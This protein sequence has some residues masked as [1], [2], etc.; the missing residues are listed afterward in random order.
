MGR[1]IGTKRRQRRGTFAAGRARV[2]ATRRLVAER[3]EPRM[4]LAADLLHVG[5]V[6][7]ETDF[8]ESESGNGS[9]EVADRFLLSF[10]GGA[11]DTQLREIRI[12]LDKDQDGLSVGDLIFDTAAGGRGKGAWHPFRVARIDSVSGERANVEAE[13]ADGGTELLVRLDQ[14]RSG[15]LLEFTI[16][17]DEVLRNH[18][19]LDRFN[20][21]LDVIASGQEMQDS[22]F[23]A[24][25]VAPHYEP[26]T[27]ETLFV[28]DYGNP[29]A[30]F[31]LRLPPNQGPPPDSF[32]S[33]TA[34]AVTTGV[35]QPKPISI[36]GTVWVDNDLDLVRRASEPGV[37]GVQL[38]LLR[39]DAGT[40]AWLDTGFRQVTNSQGGYEFGTSL[41]L[42]PGNYRVVQSPVKG[43]F[44]VG[45]VTGSVADQPTGRVI[46][47]NVISDIRML[48][49][50]THGRDYDFAHARPAELSGAVYLDD[51]DN[52]R[53][54]VGEPGLGGSRIRLVPIET[55]VAIETIETISRADGSFVFEGLPPGR[56]ELIQVTQPTGLQDG[57]DRPGTVDGRSV[58][59][60]D[61][62]G[63]AIRGIELLGG[64][65]GIDYWFGELALGELSGGVYLPPPG[66]DCGVSPDRKLPLEGVVIELLGPGGVTVASTTTGVDGRYRFQAIPKGAYTIVQTSP[67]GLLGGRAFVGII[68]GITVGSAVG[69]GMISEILMPAGG[70]GTRYD[71]CEAAPASLSGYVYHDAND[72]GR[73]DTGESPIAG[74]EIELYGTS[75]QPV[76]RTRT[77]AQ[78]RYEFNGLVP[79]EYQVRQV[80]PA[81]YFDGTDSAGSVDGIAIGVAENP[82]DRITGILLRQ[83]QTGIDYNFGELLSAS[84]SG[85]V[86]ADD[87]RNGRL[88]P[89]EN[90]LAGV[91]IE[92]WDAEDNRI[93]ARLTDDSGVYR[94]EGLRPGTYSLR[95]T[96]PTDFFQ[97]EEL[98]GTF[99]GDTTLENRID[100][101]RLPSAAVATE[102]D[103]TELSPARISGYVFRDGSVIVTERMP[104]PDE[105]RRFR[106]G[107]RRSDSLPISGVLIQLRDESGR[108]VAT[109]RLLPGVGADGLQIVTDQQGYFEFVGLAPGGYSLYQVQPAGYVDGL[110]TPGPLG[111]IAINAADLATDPRVSELAARLRSDPATD[112][113]HDAIVG[114]WLAPGDN[115]TENWFAEIEVVLVEPKLAEP[116]PPPPAPPL[117]P[118]PAP[119]EPPAE[120]QPVPPLLAPAIENAD[121]GVPVWDTFAGGLHVSSFGIHDQHL[122]TLLADSEYVVTWHLSVLNG[123]F[124][125]GNDQRSGLFKYT[126]GREHSGPAEPPGRIGRWLFVDRAGRRVEFGQAFLLGAEDGI[127][128]VGDFNGDGVDQIAIYASGQWFVDLNGNGV[129]DHGDLWLKLGTELDRPVVGDWDGDG[130]ADI[131]IFGRQ[132]EGDPEA[133]RRDPGLPT[134]ANKRRRHQPHA[135]VSQT[136]R[137]ARSESSREVV[138]GRLTDLAVDAVDHVFRYG[139]PPDTPVAGDWNGDGLDSVGI[140][141]GGRWTLDS[142]GDGRLTKDDD[143]AD[144]GQP[145]DIPIVG[146]WNGDGTANLGVV[147]GDWWIIDSD[148]DR[149]LTDNDYRVRIEKPSDNARPVTGDWDGDGQDEFGW[150]D[151]AG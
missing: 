92:L 35:Q 102:Y 119:P 24:D 33:R 145:G 22:W 77:D 68:D 13:V 14:F 7:I 78:G 89:G 95:Q 126:S 108:P 57:V 72:N 50:D 62:P 46:D 82:G 80:Q 61:E 76:L 123:G 31:G 101:I 112:P 69:L 27:L 110:D 147:R 74:V 52:G 18:A 65:V 87:N 99:G 19:D 56:Y 135:L 9:D 29:K 115:A 83:G 128:L 105:L 150:Y 127:P 125:R 121:N 42:M 70:I 136:D 16:D 81:G 120:P 58:G 144:F 17:V 100:A 114:I 51:N 132:W 26:L 41:G 107:V 75:G 28:A 133:I 84:I 60:A 3:L 122:T 130:K 143:T 85:R 43:L 53:R 67:E 139:E 97:G 117:P 71:F 45:A 59:I 25:F 131:A 1:S 129:W 38:T 44:G 8:L 73:R 66:E 55:L 23:W 138:R 88:D 15:D 124:P 32:P 106:D 79:G 91:V 36:A 54:D 116:P 146:D 30:E 149:R 37:A 64:S 90:L 47:Q 142:D 49:G 86:Y 113:N 40:G 10:T 141:R 5:I 111:G 134:V 4:L 103:F 93:D 34:A 39:Q 48:L 148:G 151:E 109:Q 98:P 21:A 11:A 2:P 137:N 94:F 6:Y 118:P 104:E 63:D 140:F 12:S 96:Q 20:A